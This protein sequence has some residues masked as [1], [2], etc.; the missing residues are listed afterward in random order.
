MNKKLMREIIIAMMYASGLDPLL[1]D[2]YY[3]NPSATNIGRFLEAV[4]CYFKIKRDAWITHYNNIGYL[5]SPSETIKFFQDNIDA[6][7]CLE[8][9][10]K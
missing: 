1:D 6:I 2:D 9:E 10:E 4:T 7:I 8:S 3:Q 5:D